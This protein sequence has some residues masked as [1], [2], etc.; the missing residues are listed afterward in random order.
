MKKIVVGNELAVADL[1]IRC[2]LTRGMKNRSR[3]IRGEE[4]HSSP[5]QG[6]YQRFHWH[7]LTSDLDYEHMSV[8]DKLRQLGITLPAPP[9]P[10]GNYVSAKTVGNLLFLAGVI[11]TGLNGVITGTVGSDRTIDEGY[12]A[13]RACALT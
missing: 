7:I 10:G 12:D 1:E 9:A 11:S 3:W 5:K 4:P 8:E 13:A 6:S 2:S